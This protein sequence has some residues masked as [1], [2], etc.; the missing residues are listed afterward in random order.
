MMEVSLPGSDPRTCL[1]VSS[2]Y[3]VSVAS[4]GGRYTEWTVSYGS[5]GPG[6]VVWADIEHTPGDLSPSC[7]EIVDDPGVT[8]RIVVRRA[9]IDPHYWAL[10]LAG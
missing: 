3:S 7:G 2:Q 4:C 6:S 5:D 9:P 1:R 10:Q 8:A